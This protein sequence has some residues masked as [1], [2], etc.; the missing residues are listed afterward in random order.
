VDLRPVYEHIFRF[1]KSEG[2]NWH[3]RELYFDFLLNLKREMEAKNTAVENDEDDFSFG[4]L[5]AIASY[6]ELGEPN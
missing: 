4:T 3:F 5:E 1:L 6:L 2:I